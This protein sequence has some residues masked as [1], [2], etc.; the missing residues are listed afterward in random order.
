VVEV[1]VRD[2]H[3]VHPVEGRPFGQGAGVDHQDAVAFEADAGMGVLDQ[4][5][6]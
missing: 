5:H 6:S 2:E 4:S 1:F 3:R